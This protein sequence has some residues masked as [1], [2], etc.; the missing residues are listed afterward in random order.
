MLPTPFFRIGS[1]IK[2]APTTAQPMKMAE[3]LGVWFVEV[4]PSLDEAPNDVTAMLR[5]IVVT[6]AR[7]SKTGQRVNIPAL[8]DILAAESGVPTA[9][10]LSDPLALAQH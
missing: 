6:V 9:V 10:P 2:A 5:E 4:H 3:H 8:R 1:T 7:T